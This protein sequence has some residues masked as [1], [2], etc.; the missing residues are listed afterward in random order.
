MAIGEAGQFGL[1]PLSEPQR[2]ESH[3]VAAGQTVFKGSLLKMSSGAVLV[4]PDADTTA[5]VGVAMAGA[6]AGEKVLVC[7]DENMIYKVLS[8][9]N[10]LILPA[11][12]GNFFAH[13]GNTVVNAAGNASNITVGGLTGVAA[14]TTNKVLQLIGASGDTGDDGTSLV[15]RIA[16]LKTSS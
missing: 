14:V 5:P 12:I 10:P 1:V 16:T 15:V 13:V 4:R 8:D 2:Y 7:T 11:S 9:I 6:A 3:L